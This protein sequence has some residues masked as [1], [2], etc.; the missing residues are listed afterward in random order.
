[1]RHSRDVPPAGYTR[2]APEP[3]GRA[4]RH[5]AEHR[6]PERRRAFRMPR[7][8]P[9]VAL[10]LV[11]SAGIVAVVVYGMA[12]TPPAHPVTPDA[13]P[14]PTP[15]PVPPLPD[16]PRPSG[17]ATSGKALLPDG[18]AAGRGR[19]GQDGR[20]GRNG[21]PEPE[22]GAASPA[23]PRPARNPR[24][25]PAPRPSSPHM[26]PKAPPATPAWVTAECRKRFPNDPRRRAA[27]AA[28]LADYMAR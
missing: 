17:P 18:E 4:R 6:R 13:V 28:A 3:P 11:L 1:M 20:D 5:R 16:P 15:P 2:A 14:T 7:Q 19:P 10:A 27:C 8:F 24:P 26:A 12:R 23:R 21:R 25:R 9:A 22:P